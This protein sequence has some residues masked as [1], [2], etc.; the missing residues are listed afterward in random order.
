MFIQIYLTIGSLPECN[1]DERSKCFLNKYKKLKNN[2][3]CKDNSGYIYK[4]IGNSGL[5]ILI[6][7]NKYEEDLV[8]RGSG[9]NEGNIGFYLKNDKGELITTTNIL[10]K[11]HY[12]SSEG[13]CDEVE[14]SLVHSGYYRNS[15]SYQETYE[16]IIPYI[17]CTEGSNKCEAISVIK[18]NSNDCSSAGIGGIIAVKSGIT[19]NYKL[20][21]NNKVEGDAVSVSTPNKYFIS[22]DNSNIF[23]HSKGKYALVDIDENENILKEVSKVKKYYY[24][25]ANLKVYSEENKEEICEEGILINEFGLTDEENI[26]YSKN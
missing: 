18:T 26:Y 22:I 4:G 14:S 17:K 25:D 19:V 2:E 5:C 10:G 6:G 16:K 3:F 7:Y 20:C 9:S 11:L 24:T 13:N 23:G 12:C 21:L 15:D 8:I 1:V